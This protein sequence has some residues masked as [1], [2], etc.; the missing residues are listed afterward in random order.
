[1]KILILQP[2]EYHY[3]RKLHLQPCCLRLQ[4]IYD[5]KMRILLRKLNGVLEVYIRQLPFAP[6]LSNS[7]TMSRPTVVYAGRSF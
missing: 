5:S 3:K 6:I 1:M 7:W 4:D 2:L